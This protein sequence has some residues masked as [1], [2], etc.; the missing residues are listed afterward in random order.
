V[1]KTLEEKN[2]ADDFILKSLM[3]IKNCTVGHFS[4][5]AAYWNHIFFLAI[6][7]AI[8]Y[9]ANS[10][11]TVLIAAK[12]RGASASLHWKTLAGKIRLQICQK[13]I[14]LGA[15]SKHATKVM[16]FQLEYIVSALTVAIERC[17]KIISTMG[18]YE[19]RPDAAALK[20]LKT[21]SLMV[22]LFCRPAGCLIGA[23]LMFYQWDSV[24]GCVAWALSFFF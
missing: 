12:A 19:T 15:A 6:I 13:I 14:A 2:M 22:E 23:L 20:N 17:R 11:C 10:I 1:L 5:G 9:N 7:T 24:R 3:I 18:K 21:A 8:C 16:L 4:I